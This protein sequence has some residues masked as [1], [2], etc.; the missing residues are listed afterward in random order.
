[1]AKKGD[2][3]QCDTCG[4]VLVVEDPCSCAACDVICCGAP[5]KPVKS[6]RPAKT[7]AAAKAAPAKTPTKK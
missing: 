4:V 7:A 3:Y 2:K 6:A 1:M 5:M